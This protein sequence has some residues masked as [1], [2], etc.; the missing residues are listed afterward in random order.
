MPAEAHPKRDNCKKIYQKYNPGD[1]QENSAA[2]LVASLDMLTIDVA[3]SPKGDLVVCCHSGPPDWGTGP[4]GKGR[5]FEISY[6]DE[7]APQPVVAS[8]S[9]TVTA[10]VAGPPAPNSRL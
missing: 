7:K 8:L 5:V 10:Q 2:V 6:V 9:G 1:G 3:T 4:T